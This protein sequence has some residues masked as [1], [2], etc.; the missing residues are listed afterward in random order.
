MIEQSM[1][2]KSELSGGGENRSCFP[3]DSLFAGLHNSVSL[4]L[5]SCK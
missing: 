3:N 2:C 4:L 5:K 1:L